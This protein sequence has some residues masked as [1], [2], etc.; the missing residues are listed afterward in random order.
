MAKN[1]SFWSGQRL[2]E[3]W[4]IYSTELA[5]HIYQGLPAL[6]MKEGKFFQV[7]PEEVNNFDADHITDFVFDPNAVLTFEKEHGLSPIKESESDDDKFS[8]EDARQFGML[9]RQK[10]KLD[11]SILAA[12]QIAIYCANTDHRITRDEMGDMIYKIDNDIPKSICE[13]IWQALP[14][15]MKKGPGR[16]K[17]E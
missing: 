1:T 16:P 14:D 6:Q 15:Q 12:V 7:P 11:A 9:K 17:K 5:A 4:G 8:R 13:L 3:R 10:L 2:M